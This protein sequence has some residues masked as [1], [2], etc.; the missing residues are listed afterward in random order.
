MIYTSGDLVHLLKPHRALWC[1]V[2]HW[3]ADRLDLASA[4]GMPQY[5]TPKGGLAATPGTLR[6][7]TTE[8]IT[9]RVPTTAT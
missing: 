1:I 4:R 2:M 6:L 3:L 8:V 7:P 9:L 5:N